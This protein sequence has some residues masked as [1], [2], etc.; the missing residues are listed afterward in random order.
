MSSTKE[1]KCTIPH[2]YAGRAY[3]V[4]ILHKGMH[5]PQFTISIKRVKNNKGLRGYWS[6][7]LNEL[8]MARFSAQ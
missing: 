4:V 7:C 2:K 8:I 5:I 1:L 6:F 3:Y